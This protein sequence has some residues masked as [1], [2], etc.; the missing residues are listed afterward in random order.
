MNL[1]DIVTIR[2]TQ[3]GHI[4]SEAV[5]VG[6]KALRR[7]NNELH[8]RAVPIRTSATEMARSLPKVGAHRNHG[9]SGVDVLLIRAD[10][11]EEAERKLLASYAESPS[12]EATSERG[13]TEAA[14]AWAADR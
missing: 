11:I 12:C 13:P 1:N 7:L 3:Y 5:L 2:V 9:I 4:K 8:V 6:P 10:T 14:Q